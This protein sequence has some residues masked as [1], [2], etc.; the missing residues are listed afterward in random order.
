MRGECRTQN[1]ERRMQNAESGVTLTPTLSRAR[2][3]ET[4]ADSGVRDSVRSA[5]GGKRTAKAGLV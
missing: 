3:R 4:G 1:T 2:E 5:V